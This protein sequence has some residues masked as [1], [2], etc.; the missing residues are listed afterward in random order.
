M[1]TDAFHLSHKNPIVKEL[2]QLPI[3]LFNKDNIKEKKKQ[4]R[5]KGKF[6]L[7]GDNGAE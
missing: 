7:N 1:A 5:R 4:S 6:R 2:W 3:K